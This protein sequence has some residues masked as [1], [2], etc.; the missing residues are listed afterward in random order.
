MY[1]LFYSAAHSAISK[2]KNAKNEF[3]PPNTTL[4]L[5]PLDQ[6]IIQSFKV[7]YSHHVIKKMSKMEDGVSPAVVIVIKAMRMVDKTQSNVSGRFVKNHERIKQLI[8]IILLKT[9]PKIIGTD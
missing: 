5:E 7:K 1:F 8:L 4:K 3:L 2:K 6:G 9:A